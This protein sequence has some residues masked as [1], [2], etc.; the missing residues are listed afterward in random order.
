MQRNTH[1]G[2]VVL[3]RDDDLP[4]NK[5]PLARITKV[6][7]SKDGLVRKVEL[8]ITRNGKLVILERPIQKFTFLVEDEEDREESP[9]REPR[10]K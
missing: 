6:F 2:D 9:L 5:W 8:L 1:V 4:R 10:D 7:P 3:L